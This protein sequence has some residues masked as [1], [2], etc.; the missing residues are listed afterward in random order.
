MHL[1]DNVV[2]LETWICTT[3]YIIFNLNA[4]ETIHCNVRGKYIHVVNYHAQFA[5]GICPDNII[6]VIVINAPEML[7]ML[8]VINRSYGICRMTTSAQQVCA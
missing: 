3:S 6:Y 5:A 1:A 2:S 7:R 8:C 4:F